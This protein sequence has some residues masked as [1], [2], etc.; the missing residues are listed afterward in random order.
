MGD[1]RGCY[2]AR[3]KAR[4]ARRDHHEEGARKEEPG[5]EGGALQRSGPTWLAGLA[6]A[7]G[8]SIIDLL[9]GRPAVVDFAARRPAENP[10]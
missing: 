10:A 2:E 4:R 1:S 9:S 3:R 7:S 5:E 8:L 6:A